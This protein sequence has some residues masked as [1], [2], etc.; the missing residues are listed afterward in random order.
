MDLTLGMKAKVVKGT[1][2]IIFSARRICQESR[3]EEFLKYVDL[4]Y[5]AISVKNQLD[6][7]VEIQS[8]IGL[9]ILAKYS[10][11]ITKTS[12]KTVRMAVVL[13]YCNDPDFSLEQLTKRN[14]ISAMKEMD[15]ELFDFLVLTCELN[16]IKE[17]F[18]HPKVF[19]NSKNYQVF[20]DK[21]W[22]EG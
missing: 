3:V 17:N 22:D 19:I 5:E 4:R 21:G 9:D 2:D 13:I 7:N 11:A 15:D 14:F 18:S 1:F 6:L 10:D 12:S 8:E 20:L 16:K